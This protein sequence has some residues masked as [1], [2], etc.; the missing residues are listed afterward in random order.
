[1]LSYYK[2]SST[3]SYYIYT[4]IRRHFYDKERTS[5]KGVKIVLLFINVLIH[6]SIFLPRSV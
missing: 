1:M 2:Y 6:T 4:E 5:V 3:F